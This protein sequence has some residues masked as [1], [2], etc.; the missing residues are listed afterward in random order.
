MGNEV[1]KAYANFLSSV[2]KGD[3]L[4]RE[5][6]S[7]WTALGS[8]NIICASYRISRCARE[9]NCKGKDANTILEELCRDNEG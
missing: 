3:I 5:K 8:I 7:T 9:A 2:R 6:R 1:N 4:G